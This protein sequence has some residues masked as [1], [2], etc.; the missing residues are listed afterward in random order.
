MKNVKIAVEG[1]VATVTLPLEML[2]IIRYTLHEGAMKLAGTASY[3]KG[4][5]S[6]FAESAQDTADKALA[7]SHALEE[8]NHQ[9]VYGKPKPK[10]RSQT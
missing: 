9:W 3:L 5:R 1:E 6:E 4:M 10:K 8:A 7:A 2:Q